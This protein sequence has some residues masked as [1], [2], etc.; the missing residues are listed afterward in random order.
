MRP[1]GQKDTFIAPIHVQTIRRHP[2]PRK[3]SCLAAL[4]PCPFALSPAPRASRSLAAL[5]ALTALMALALQVHVATQAPTR[6][7]GTPVW[8]WLAGYFTILTN[9][10]VAAVMGATAFGYRPSARMQGGLVLSILMV[11]LVYHA[12]LARLWAPQGLAWWADQGL[13][14]ATP[15]LVPGWWLTVGDRHITLRD[16]PAW[17]IW[18][19]LYATYA[20]IRGALTG[21]WPYPFLDAAQLGLPLVA[22]NTVGM[23]LA[24][25]AL[26]L[27]LIALARASIR[28]SIRASVR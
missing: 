9:V 28:A 12:I 4:A 15:I 18:P 26:G 23:V 11:G 17:L 3:G 27:G 8:W 1:H 24:F 6:P 25:A 10:G 19:A 14:T 22:L 2:G 21:F 13:H 7:E 16:L 20:L 5:V